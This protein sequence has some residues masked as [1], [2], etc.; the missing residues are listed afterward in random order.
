[1]TNHGQAAFAAM[2]QAVSD[3]TAGFLEPL[4][5][6]EQAALVSA[7]TKLYATTAE[8][9]RLPPHLDPAGRKP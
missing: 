2:T 3:Y 9:Q 8:G 6:A 1:M 5:P 7:L 4:D